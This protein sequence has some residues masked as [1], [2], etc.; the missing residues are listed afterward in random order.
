[1]ESTELNKTTAAPP[2]KHGGD[3]GKP[4]NL[5][6]SPSA[7]SRRSGG[8]DDDD[9]SSASSAGSSPSNKT[10][11]PPKPEATQPPA[12]QEMERSPSGYRIPASVF[13]RNKSST[14]G[15]WSVASNESLFSIHVGNMSFTNDHYMWRS[16]ELG[17]PPAAAS[18]S[19]STEQMFCYSGQ[20]SVGGANDM[21]SR[22][23]GIAE[24]T[25]L[26]VIKESEGRPQPK[27]TPE[28]RNARRSAGSNQSNMSFAFSM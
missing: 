9:C 21:R 8:D 4:K 2:P 17:P 15:D 24:A 26:E 10:R 25:M 5:S 22:E 19:T 3:A 6:P 16:G 28:A 13:E 18:A 12:S 20:S 1:M 27:L 14:P 11:K 7:D 23:L